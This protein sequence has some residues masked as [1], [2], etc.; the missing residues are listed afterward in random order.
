MSPK[1]YACNRKIFYYFYEIHKILK[2]FNFILIFWSDTL[3]EI[4]HVIRKHALLLLC[5]A[6]K[7]NWKERYQKKRNEN[8]N[9]T[10]W[11]SVV[12]ANR[13]YNEHWFSV[14]RSLFFDKPSGESIFFVRIFWRQRPEVF[15]HGL[16]ER[17]YFVDLNVLEYGTHKLF[18]IVAFSVQ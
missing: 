5:K 10:I 7:V 9:L 2:P 4:M 1:F 12:C 3:N 13:T 6:V 16:F 15:L 11:T 18:S 8:K 14:K 17:Y